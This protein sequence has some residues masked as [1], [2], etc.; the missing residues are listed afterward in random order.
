ME[1]IG[2]C[3]APKVDTLASIEV[4]CDASYVMTFYMSSI[5]WASY[6]GLGLIGAWGYALP[7]AY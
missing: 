3:R 1:I 4:T 5:A 2:D 6:A 7:E